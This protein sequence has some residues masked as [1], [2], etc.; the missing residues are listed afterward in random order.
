VLRVDPAFERI[1]RRL[2]SL[3][4]RAGADAR[5]DADLLKPGEAAGRTSSAFV[6]TYSVEGIHRVLDEYGLRAQL[7]RQGLGD[8]VIDITQDDPFRHRLAVRL[9]EGTGGDRDV[10]GRAGGRPAV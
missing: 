2:T 5:G 10:M 1:A 4:L 6:D 3:E 9:P 8:V 7:E